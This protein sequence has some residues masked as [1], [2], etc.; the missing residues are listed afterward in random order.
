MTKVSKLALIFLLASVIAIPT[1]FANAEAP[2]TPITDAYVQDE[3]IVGYFDNGTP[4]ENEAVRENS[5]KAIGADAKEKISSRVTN[6]EVLKIGKGVSVGAAIARLKNQPGIRFVEPNYIVHSMVESNDPLFM[7][8]SLWGMYGSI[9]VPANQFGS[10][11]ANAWTRG[12]VGSS[13]VVVGVIDEG[14]QVN[15][16]DLAENM[17]V[18]PGEIDGNGIDDDQN[19]YVDDINGWDFVNNNASVYDGGTAG[20]QDSHGTH[21]SGTIG[22]KGGNAKGVAGVNWNVKIISTKF[23]GP[24][25][26]STSNAVKALDY[27]TALKSRASNPVNL[28][29]TNNSWG[30]GGYSQALLDA[31]NRSGDAGMLFVVAAGNSKG[32]NDAIASYP[33]NYLCTKGLRTSD[34]V[35]AVAAINSVGSIADFSSYGATTVDLGAPGVSITSTLPSSI[36]GSYSGT[37]MATPHVTGAVA[38]CK[39]I[40]PLSTADQIRSAILESTAPTTSLATKTATGGRLDIGAMATKCANF[41]NGLQNQTT[42]LL[43]TNSSTSGTAGTAITLSTSGG[44]GSG[45]VS[46]VATGPNC[47]ISN[48]TVK[49]TAPTTCSVT[50]RKAA[51]YMYNAS[52]ISQPVVFTFNPAN[53]STLTISTSN[54]KT[55]AKGITGITLQTSGG[56]GTGAVTFATTSAGCVIISNR[57]TVATTASPGLQ[58]SC[59]VTAKKAASGI[60]REATSQPKVF[61]FK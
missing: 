41:T 45:L 2:A 28:I 16:P 17:W 42:P 48:N 35:I 58:V 33:S 54:S 50:A 53:Q 4:A 57:L 27:L 23:L 32:N 24:N 7:E 46:Y 13:D 14:V 31:I 30:G 1:T 60:Y 20:S 3:L 26:G 38:L 52:A 25:G 51:D 49:A 43:I 18:N 12:Y 34:C 56:S 36:Y 19:G 22:G 59:S 47:V 55:I 37:S 29:A 10:N 15:H 21:V 6:T 44:N 39:S 8:S 5:Y 61:N 40:Y 11:A 9:S